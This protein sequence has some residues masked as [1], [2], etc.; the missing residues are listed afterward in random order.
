M[1]V[2]TKRCYKLKRQKSAPT[3][4]YLSHRRRCSWNT[5]SVVPLLIMWLLYITPCHHGIHLH[6][7]CQTATLACES[8]CIEFLLS[9]WEKGPWRA[10]TEHFRQ[11]MRKLVCLLSINSILVIIQNSW[12]WTWKWTPLSALKF[13]IGLPLQVKH[14]RWKCLFC[15]RSTSP[16]HGSPHL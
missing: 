10:T 15:T 2:F 8:W 12:T 3:E 6:N 9:I 14:L 16:L 11:S 5:S 1:L 4:A 7:S 13:T